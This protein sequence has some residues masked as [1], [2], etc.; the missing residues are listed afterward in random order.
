MRGSGGYPKGAAWST[1]PQGLLLRPAIPSEEMFDE[2]GTY[3]PK[4]NFKISLRELPESGPFRVTVTAAKY[5]DGLLLDPG[6]APA[7]ATNQEIVYKPLKS[8]ATVTIPQ[9]GIYQVDAYTAAETAKAAPDS[10]RLNE[11]L[12]MVLPAPDSGSRKSSPALR[13]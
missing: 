10:S 7:T 2:D 13:T 4:A 9:A 8:P 6:A 11:G 5:N 1:V 12:S 3:G